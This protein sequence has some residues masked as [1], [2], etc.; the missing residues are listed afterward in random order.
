MSTD[1]DNE[2]EP[3]LMD[4]INVV[5]LAELNRITNH[6]KP[7]PTICVTSSTLGSTPTQALV[8]SGATMVHM[9]VAFTTHSRASP[10]LVLA[11]IAELL[12]TVLSTAWAYDVIPAGN[13]NAIHSSH[14]CRL[15]I[16]LAWAEALAC[17]AELL[18][19]ASSMAWAFA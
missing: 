17:I 1:A 7:R 10:T 6:H 9:S 2:L 11:C 3:T 12:L 16:A 13:N 8:G 5:Q 14:C 19:T 15:R 18:M 4:N